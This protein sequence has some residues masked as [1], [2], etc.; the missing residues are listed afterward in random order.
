MKKYILTIIIFTTISL[1]SKAQNKYELIGKWTCTDVLDKEEIPSAGLDYLEDTI[2]NKWSIVLEKDSA[3]K[4][5]IVDTDSAEG[6]W[7]YNITSKSIIVKGI[8]GSDLK[9]EILKFDKNKIDLKSRL[10]KFTLEK[11]ID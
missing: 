10:G 3:F 7:E 6:I 8:E 4:T 5:E 9:F 2:V 1:T 11:E